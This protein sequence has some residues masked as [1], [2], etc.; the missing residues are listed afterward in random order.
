MNSTVNLSQLITRL[1]EITESD[2]NTARRFLHDFFAL[3][4]TELV[5]G[6]EVDIKGIG[7]FRRLDGS[8]AADS[9]P[10][11]GFIPAESLAEAINAPFAMFEPVE[12]AE[13][14]DE[15]ALAAC[16][17]EEPALTED[18][19]TESSSPDETSASAE[20]SQEEIHPQDETETYP[21]ETMTEDNAT[22]EVAVCTVEAT[23]N[24]V[25]QD[26][27]QIP[28]NNYIAESD[29]NFDS[30]GEQAVH[31][32]R[33]RRGLWALAGLIFGLSAGYGISWLTAP[34]PAPDY[35]YVFEEEVEI[36]AENDSEEAS[37]AETGADEASE[38]N[39]ITPET[40]ET[41]KAATSIQEDP[42]ENETENTIEVEPSDVV[43]DTVTKNRFLATMSRAHYGGAMEYW[44]YIYE[45]NRDRLGH[46]DRIEPG[47]R[48]VIPPISSFAPEG[49]T[50]RARAEAVRLAS[51]I[52]SRFK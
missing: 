3:I 21:E 17:T 27:E 10:S 11:V 14:V 35:D 33:P 16:D 51:E 6:N 20:I 30:V 31:R 45:A 41:G 38:N 32:R 8:T 9:T 50:P 47:T 28:G 26:T 42:A 2:P 44:V 22:E 23:E 12:L 19:D 40:V 25:L 29:D 18:A 7:T 52:Y 39:T 5:A 48:V 4:E 1:S 13:G 24:E 34:M 49:D 36:I 43:Y 15:A 46:P 37:Y